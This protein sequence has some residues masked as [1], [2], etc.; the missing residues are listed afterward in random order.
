[1]KILFLGDIVGRSGREAAAAYVKAQR[2][3]VDFVVVNAENA[4][5]GFGLTP[6]ICEELFKAGADVIT[7]GNHVWDQLE[8]VPTLSKDKRVLRP[9]NYPAAVAGGGTALIEKNGQKL[10]VIHLMGQIHMH[11]SMDCPFAAADKVLAQYKLGA[12]AD[13]I[14][15]DFHAE[16]T[17][18]KTAMGHHLDGR[19]SLVVGTHTHIPTA[20]GRVLGGGTAYQTDAGMCGDYDSCIGMQKEAVLKRFLTKIAKGNRMEA[21]TGVATVCG[22]VVETDDKTGLA[23]SVA[24]IRVGGILG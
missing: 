1:M 4:A 19:A 22:V 7:T 9:L 20:D 10:L 8:I 5:G 11:E 18:E 14:V 2:G 3:N 6:A 16:A 24:P 23:K 13:A 12:G 17:S 21:A 15:V